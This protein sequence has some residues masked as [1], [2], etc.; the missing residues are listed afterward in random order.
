VAAMDTLRRKMDWTGHEDGVVRQARAGRLSVRERIALLVD[1]GSWR[2][3]GSL[4]GRMVVDAAAPPRLAAVVPANF[5]GGRALI[6]GRPVVVAADDFSIRGGHADG[7]LARK[8]GYTESV[9][10]ALRLPLVRLL[11]GASGG[12]SVASLLEMGATYVPPL[13]G[14]AGMVAM[15]GEVPVAAALLGP[16]VG[17]AAARATLTHFSVMV[18]GSAQLFVAGPPV[19]HQATG[20]CQARGRRLLWGVTWKVFA[21]CV[22]VLGSVHAFVCVCMC[23]CAVGGAAGDLTVT[24]EALGGAHIH[25]ANGAVDNV[26]GTEAEAL[27]QIARFLTY[28]PSSAWELPP[29]TATADPPD[30]RDAS[31]LAAVPRERRRPFDVRAIIA[32]VVDDGSFFEVWGA[33][34]PA[35]GAWATALTRAGRGADWRRVGPLAGGRAGAPARVRGRGARQRPQRGRRHHDGRLRTKGRCGTRV[36]TVREGPRALTMWAC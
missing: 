10:R 29:R 4:A 27:L 25:G 28:L 36:C 19:V 7:A 31:L 15:L 22:R 32:S 20:T 35:K 18:R 9:A 1:R 13:L 5:V 2:E 34:Y 8:Q 24:K 21:L 16:V 30:R 26:A 6:G 12:G 23:V 17:F 3:V 14:A 33:A 11:D